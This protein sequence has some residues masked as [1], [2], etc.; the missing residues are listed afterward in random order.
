MDLLGQLTDMHIR[1]GPDD[2]EGA[3]RVAA[4]VAAAAAFAPVLTAVVITGDIAENGTEREY[5]R[6][7]ELLAP[8]TMPI[9]VVAGNHDD[10]DALAAAFGTETCWAARVGSL[11]V[12][13]CDSSVP[14]SD[15]GA[16]GA[17]R[18]AWIGKRLAEDTAT[19]TI[20]AMH[21]PPVDTGVRAMDEIGIP[22]PDRAALGELLASN[23]QVRRV[24][25]GH[26]HRVA[27]ATLG[28]CPVVL[29]PSCERQL[30][31]DLAGGDDLEFTAEPPG[32]MVH[33]VQNGDIVSH[34]QPIT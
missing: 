3:R 20:L 26:V 1:V 10:S 13:G 34:V 4:T 12:I 14:G 6:A 25:S 29:S 21:H 11:R 7:Q 15:G 32:F 16:L 19:P 27:T 33:V 23:R 18:L 31:L 8:L 9:H 30:A 22:V 2:V 17:D 24:I 5:E 28:G